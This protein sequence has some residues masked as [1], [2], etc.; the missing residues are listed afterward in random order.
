VAVVANQVYR[1]AEY[2][3]AFDRQEGLEHMRNWLFLTGSLPAL[4]QV[5]EHYGI[6]ADVEPAGA[7]I[8][9]SDLAYLIDAHGRTREV[10]STEPGNGAA[11][12]SS[13]S[14]Y[15]AS[16]LERVIHA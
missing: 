9:H 5:W 10:L 7:M 2:A 15:L 11:S 1:S 6:V 3:N 12:S 13:F 16:A 8:A 4:E 14:E